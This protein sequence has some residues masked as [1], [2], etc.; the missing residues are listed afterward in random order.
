MTKYLSAKEKA[1]E[2]GITTSGLAKTRHLYKHIRKSPHKYLY[3]E[4]DPREAVR[5]VVLEQDDLVAGRRGE[6]PRVGEI[7]AFGEPLADRESGGRIEARRLC[8]GIDEG[9]RQLE[10]VDAK[11]LFHHATDLRGQRTGQRPRGGSA[12][13]SLL[14]RD[15]GAVLKEL[16]ILPRRDVAEQQAED[17]H[18]CQRRIGLK[19]RCQTV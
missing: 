18:F 8:V 1:E 11:G 3:F 19:R 2:L 15:V 12:Q 5:L 7:D 14:W 17:F 6:A 9:W 16:H 13:Q 10:R 4:E